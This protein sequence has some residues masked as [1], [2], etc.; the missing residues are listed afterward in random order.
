MGGGMWAGKGGGCGP[1]QKG[2]YNDGMMG[3]NGGMMGQMSR[4]APYGGCGKGMVGAAMGKGP[5]LDMGKG[6]ALGKSSGK[7]KGDPW[8]CVCGNV[9]FA[10]REVC[11]MRSCGLP[12][13]APAAALS[14]GVR[15]NLDA[16]WTCGQCGNKNFA[17][18]EVCNMRS[19]QAARPF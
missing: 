2:M 7:G 5:A 4:A 18:R 10:D 12:K 16:G 13:P 15:S 11:N 3:C 6:P 8:T 14:A 1:M 17:D 19:C 9:N